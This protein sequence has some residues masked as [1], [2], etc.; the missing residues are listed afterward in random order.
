M[1]QRQIEDLKAERRNLLHDLAQTK[2]DLCKCKL[3]GRI[4]SVS[5]ITFSMFHMLRRS[6]LIR[7]QLLRNVE[8]C[9]AIC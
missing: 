4:L 7:L 2:S 8:S 6:L 9:L 5:R 3:Q 1:L